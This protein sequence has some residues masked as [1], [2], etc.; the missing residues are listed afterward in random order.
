MAAGRLREVCVTSSAGDPAPYPFRYPFCAM[1]ITVT[2]RSLGGGQEEAY[3]YRY[4]PHTG[5]T[6]FEIATILPILIAAWGQ[7]NEHQVMGEGKIKTWM[8]ANVEGLPEA[9]KRHFQRQEGYAS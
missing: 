6:P 9:A 7:M 4:A 2:R 5:I 1:P 8:N 3:H